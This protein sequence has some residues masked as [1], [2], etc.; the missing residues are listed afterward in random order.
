MK[1]PRRIPPEAP[2]RSASLRCFCKTEG[3]DSPDVVRGVF[4][5]HGFISPAFQTGNG[6]DRPG[7]R[8]FA[9]QRGIPPDSPIWKWENVNGNHGRP[10]KPASTKLSLNDCHIPA[11]H[12]T[13][14]SHH[15]TKLNLQ[16]NYRHEHRLDCLSPAKSGNSTR[17][18][19]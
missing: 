12:Q 10:R 17:S 16:C 13:N 15:E 2:P 11:I 5:L 18:G 7:R 19:K 9:P 3:Q 1:K 8:F 6:H 4:A 14:Q